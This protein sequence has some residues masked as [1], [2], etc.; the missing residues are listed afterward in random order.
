MDPRNSIQPK[1][2]VKQVVNEACFMEA[3]RLLAARTRCERRP[4]HRVGVGWYKLSIPRMWSLFDFWAVQA[5][6][7]GV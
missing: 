1:N 3:G 5:Q 4:L 7:M 2:P 6:G